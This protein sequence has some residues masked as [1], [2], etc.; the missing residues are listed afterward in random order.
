MAGRSTRP[1]SGAN[2]KQGAD[3]KTGRPGHGFAASP[4][5]KPGHD[6]LGSDAGARKNSVGPGD[7]RSGMVKHFC[8]RGRGGFG[9]G[10]RTV[11]EVSRS[12]EGGSSP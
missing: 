5:A 6:E 1:S 10:T 3:V 4:H 2:H 11:G 12:Y 9:V 7:E 8:P